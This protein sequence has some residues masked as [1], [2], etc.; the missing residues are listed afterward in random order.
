MIIILTISIL[1]E[2]VAVLN[3]GSS[4]ASIYDTS[5]GTAFNLSQASDLQRNR[6]NSINEHFKSSLNKIIASDDLTKNLKDLRSMLSSINNTPE[7]NDDLPFP[8]PPPGV[9]GYTAPPFNLHDPQ[10]QSLYPLQSLQLQEQHQQQ[11]QSP[12]SPSS[13]SQ[14]LPTLAALPG[15][16]QPQQQQPSNGSPQTQVRGRRRSKHNTNNT[17]QTSPLQNSINYEPTSNSEY[18]LFSSPVIT[19]LLTIITKLSEKVDSLEEKLRNDNNNNITNNDNNDN[20]HVNH[21]E[22]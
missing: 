17:L 1:S 19:S 18:D 10:Q 5:N 15:Q 21:T 9:P 11:Q 22:K 8:P 14:Q 16:L 4:S 13:Q 3:S 2:K 6:R 20:T 12:Q 7:L